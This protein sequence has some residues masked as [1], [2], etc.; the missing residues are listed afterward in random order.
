[1]ATTP[2]WYTIPTNATS[3]FDIPAVQGLDNP[4]A[5]LPSGQGYAQQA[6][7]YAN[8]YA[9]Q[10]GNLP[11]MGRDFYAAYA[12]SAVGSKD[13]STKYN[14]QLNAMINPTLQLA[15]Q[16]AN[17]AAL[18][19]TRAPGR[20]YN[21]RGLPSQQS[22][23]YQQMLDAVAGLGQ[24]RSQQAYSNIRGEEAQRASL[25]QS[26]AQLA[27]QQ[28]QAVQA[29]RLA[30][31]QLQMQEAYQ[32]AQMQ[33]Q[34]REL[35]LPYMAQGANKLS[36]DELAIQRRQAD[37]YGYAAKA[38]IQAQMDKENAAQTLQSYYT[39]QL[40]GT[41]GQPITNAGREQQF[42]LQKMIEQALIAQ[43]VAS[44]V[45]RKQD[46][47]QIMGYGTGGGPPQSMPLNWATGLGTAMGKYW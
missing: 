36:P 24:Q 20:S 11:N 7:N 12:P 19:S 8:Q 35:L 45:Q 2:P 1:M 42:A 44:P 38:A 31:L 17:R 6:T 22:A 23:M 13:Y 21:A 33:Q 18:A 30:S 29:A 43:G 41:Y 14:A 39:G 27:A 9:N 3:I 37:P 40:G 16:V 4:Y 32:R 28:A 5:A 47:N 26:G 15:K 46:M 10:W 25:A 34:M